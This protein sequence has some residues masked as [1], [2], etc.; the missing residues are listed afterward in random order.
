MLDMN[1]FN[2]DNSIDKECNASKASLSGRMNDANDC[3]PKLIKPKRRDLTIQTDDS[4]LKIARRLDQIRT[5]R[6]E[7]LHICMAKPLKKR[8]SGS[9]SKQRIEKSDERRAYQQESSKK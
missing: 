1:N 8:E 3:T 5:N 4:Y 6:T 9:S 7:S 2:S